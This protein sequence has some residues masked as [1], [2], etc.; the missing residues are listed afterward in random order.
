V[1]KQLAQTR[2][3]VR[4]TAKANAINS[5]TDACVDLN[6]SSGPTGCSQRVGRL[7]TKRNTRHIVTHYK[8]TRDLTQNEQNKNRYQNTYSSLFM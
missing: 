3:K 6:P 5:A 8:V 4:A 1:S 2:Y 7:C